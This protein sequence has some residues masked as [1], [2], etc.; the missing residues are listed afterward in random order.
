M[1][2]HNEQRPMMIKGHGLDLPDKHF[3]AAIIKC[4]NEQF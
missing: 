4:S 3:V 1:K 2:K